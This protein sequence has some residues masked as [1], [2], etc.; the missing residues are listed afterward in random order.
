MKYV[1]ILCVADQS[2]H[3]RLGNLNSVIPDWR[4]LYIF[5]WNVFLNLKSMLRKMFFVA[6]AS[7]LRKHFLHYFIMDFYHSA[8]EYLIFIQF[9]NF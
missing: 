6:N 3:V 1:F 8:V 9:H 7:I 2:F 4:F 5:F